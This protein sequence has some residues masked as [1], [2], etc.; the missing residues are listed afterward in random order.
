MDNFQRIVFLL[1]TLLFGFILSGC[2]GGSGSGSGS[3][4][5]SLVVSQSSINF[6]S[7]SMGSTPA[8]QTVEVSINNPDSTVYLGVFYTQDAIDSVTYDL[9]SST[10]PITIYAKAPGA[11]TSGT[12]TD[13]VTVVACKDQNC[14]S[15]VSGSPFTI[16]VT[17][18]ISDLSTTPSAIAF[19]AQEGQ[20]PASQILSVNN[21]NTGSAWSSSITYQGS[22]SGWLHVS[23]ASGSGSSASLSVNADPLPAGSYSASIV[24][25]AGAKS[26]SVPVTYT[27]SSTIS[28][29][30]NA[31]VFNVVEGSSA[32][33]KEIDLSG[34]TTAWSVSVRYIDST[35]WLSV[36]PTSG[37]SS[38]DT[39]SVIPTGL[40]AGTYSAEVVITYKVGAMTSELAIPV[41]YVVEPIK[42]QTPA[43]AN[44]NLDLRSTIADTQQVVTI[45][46]NSD[47]NINWN[48]TSSANWLKI[49][50]VSGDTG[51]QNQL[52][53][54]LDTEVLRTLESNTYK[55]KVT[56][57][58]NQPRVASAQI[59]VQLVLDKASID[60]VA[61]YVLYENQ[62][63]NITLKGSGLLQA[64]GLSIAV[65]SIEISDFTVVD[66][67]EIRIKIPGLTAG[68]YDFH[69]IDDLGISPTSGR[70]LVKSV[71]KYQDAVV[72]IHGRPE[73]IEYDPERDAFFGVFWDLVYGA[74]FVAQRIRFNGSQWEVDDLSV[75]QPLAV[76]LTLDGSELLVT[77]EN[78]EVIHI[79]PETLAI[80][81]TSTF[82]GSC[83][84]ERFG[85]LNNFD[86]GQILV[87]NTNQWP[88]AW[89]Y[90]A[91]T[92]FSVP[93]V[94]N[95]IS[96]RSRNRNAMLWAE[97]PTISGLRSIYLY[98]S[99]TDTFTSF[100]VHDSGTY[101]LPYNLAINDDG[102]RLI[103]Q[104]DVYDDNQLYIGSLAGLTYNGLDRVGISPDGSRA[105]RFSYASK[106]LTIFDLST[107][108]GQFPQSGGDIVLPAGTFDKAFNVEISQDGSTGF[109][110]GSKEAT[111]STTE[112][113]LN[114]T[115]L[116]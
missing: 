95:P 74:D 15:H 79:D 90:P 105:V 71:P 41:T 54:T 59:V 97:S 87:A 58:G 8:P 52:S 39:L 104:F 115:V 30:P 75:Q 83:Y 68:E 80:N 56:I 38:S 116:P 6:V 60:F 73:S 111:Q 82:T 109:V 31:L 107:D 9:T 26:V 25:T 40:L 20:A 91:F 63:R 17:Y 12:H 14:D 66:D 64:A 16:H 3:G 34:L 27:I 36:S 4:S 51:S 42:L 112:F 70:L 84:P 45:T 35:G 81:S 48:A 93:S 28:A 94:H 37:T 1:L 24:L 113:K 100:A 65:G 76:G 47:Q 110:F 69:I 33:S 2:G 29:S 50:P 44:F 72:S 55:A 114:V 85:M 89:E 18:T 108:T 106:N 22:T 53:L 23:P 88:R 99:K 21:T 77:T 98:S 11:L 32:F 13:E 43:N 61:P 102:S 92:T 67:E 19:S 7:D 78:C 10:V 101:F 86:D 57:A 103:H 49:S 5:S 62:A 46:T 96:I